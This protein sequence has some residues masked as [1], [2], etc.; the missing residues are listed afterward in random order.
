V[1]DM[2]SSES[3]T[4]GE[5]EGSAYNEYFGCTCYHPL[6]ATLVSNGGGR[7]VAADVRG[8]PDADRAAAGAARASMRSAGSDAKD[9]DSKGAP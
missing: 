2:D 4:Y 7:R 8:N 5:Q 1:L 9:D 6:F 3:P